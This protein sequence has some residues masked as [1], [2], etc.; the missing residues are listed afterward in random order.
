M[1]ISKKY[2]AFTVT[3]ILFAFLLV[4]GCSLGNGFDFFGNGDVEKIKD[5]V[6]MIETFDVAREPLA[7]GSGFA[8]YNSNWIITNMHVI[9]GARFI[10][11]ITD[12]GK[13]LTVEGIVL[14][15]KRDD[16]AILRIDGD[17]KPLTIGRTDNLK[18]TDKITAIG[19]PKGER[20]TVSEGIISNIDVKGEIRITAPISHGSSGGVLL[21]EHYEVIG[22]TNAG[23]DDAQNLNFAID[24]SLLESMYESYVNEKYDELNAENYV[25]FIPYHSNPDGKNALEINTKI[26]S[27]SHYNY[28]VDSLETFYLATNEFEIFDTTIEWLA[29]L[30]NMDSDG[31]GNL[32]NRYF[33]LYGDK[34]REAASNYLFLLQYETDILEETLGNTTQS[35][36]KDWVTEEYILR[37]N[38]LSIYELAVFM[39]EI[40][41]DMIA[42]GAIIDY[43]NETNMSY[44]TKIIINRLLDDKDSRYNRDII[45]YFDNDS[46]ISYEQ[47]VALLEYLGMT[48]DG[49]G[50]VWW[51]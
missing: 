19:S 18:V 27:S 50:R 33:E 49:D 9:E 31:E 3:V 26:P 5:S 51:D 10:D 29:F 32:Y 30:A 28:M 38:L 39:A 46:D 20:N 36:I 25:N 42:D 43:M 13:R 44:E 24:I 7:T 2:R 41:G 21:N 17:L 37:M 1:S 12:E 47:Q 48:V 14:Y 6:V 45:D 15:N 11:V 35:E 34:Q 22:I 40:D 4:T 8:A 16:L 23:Y